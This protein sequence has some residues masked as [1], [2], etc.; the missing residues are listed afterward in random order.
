MSNKT[1]DSILT[2]EI[3]K[4]RDAGARIA[5]SVE[6][7]CPSSRYRELS[8]ASTLAAVANRLE[9]AQKAALCA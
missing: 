2:D 3:K 9:K 1:P 6:F 7:A 4:L 5:A 8:R